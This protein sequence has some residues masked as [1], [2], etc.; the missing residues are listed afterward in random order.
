MSYLILSDYKKLI[1]ADN[2]AQILGNDYSMLPQ[3][4]SAAVSEATSYLVQKYD[5][6]KEFK[7]IEL[8][9]IGQ[10]DKYYSDRIYIDALP[11]D[12]NQIY[13]DTDKCL[14][15]GHVYYCSSTTTQGTF[16]VNKWV[17]IGR[18]YQIFSLALPNGYKYF[19]YYQ[20]YKPGDFVFYND[21]QYTV[22]LNTVGVFP[23]DSVAIFGNGTDYVM[24]ENIYTGGGSINGAWLA[25]DNRNQQ[26]VNYLIDIV[27]Y[28]LHSRISPRNIPELRVKR[29]DD[30]IAWLKQCA[31]G[32][33]ITGGLPLLQPKQ[34]SRIRHGASL[35]KQYNNY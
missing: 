21:K 31:K 11:Y 3:I 32:D 5:V 24:S 10:P 28:H 14:Y 23:T 15:N 34:G 18:Q 1:Q 22:Q 2:L 33:Y 35:S 17:D 19:D 8:E 27:L 7:P 20:Q 26:M 6:A 30:A 12:A 25:G 9:H 16:D 29:Y 13:N 4:E